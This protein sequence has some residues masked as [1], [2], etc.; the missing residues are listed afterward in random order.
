METQRTMTQPPVTNPPPTGTAMRQ[1]ITTVKVNTDNWPIREVDCF[2]KPHGMVLEAYEPGI[3]PVFAYYLAFFKS[4]RH[5]HNFSEGLEWSFSLFAT[6]IREM[7]YTYKAV[8]CKNTAEFHTYIKESI[9]KGIPLLVPGNLKGLYYTWAYQKADAPHLFLVKG[10]DEALE[11]YYIN[12]NMHHYKNPVQVES[13]EDGTF[14]DFVIPE[15]NLE[16]VWTLFAPMKI[17][18]FQETIIRIERGPNVRVPS[19]RHRLELFTE[20]A[21]SRAKPEDMFRELSCFKHLIRQAETLT[22]DQ[23]ESLL[24]QTRLNIIFANKT[25]VLSTLTQMVKDRISP[26][27]L[28]ELGQLCDT[29]SQGWNKVKNMFYFSFLGGKLK[30]IAT[31][32]QRCSPVINAE[33]KLFQLVTRLTETYDF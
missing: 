24:A 16:E 6:V 27:D 29:I 17:P 3:Y 21:A 26:G 32:E 11:L 20:L 13:D 25:Y 4:Y 12:D 8:K 10:Y 33:K 31:M 18:P 15:K 5:R 1:L 22:P 19:M 30:N 2:T 23:R 28:K 14:Y 9:K 7:G